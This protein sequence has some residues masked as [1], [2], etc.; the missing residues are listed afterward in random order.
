MEKVQ[1]SK[2]KR[3]RVYSFEPNALVRAYFSQLY[4]NYLLPA[5]LKV[6]NNRS[7]GANED[8]EIE[9]IVRFE[10]DM[11]L[12]L[13]ASGFRWSHAL[14]HK[15]KRDMVDVKASHPTSFSLFNYKHHNICRMREKLEEVSPLPPLP[16]PLFHVGSD[17]NPNP[18]SKNS[19]KKSMGVYK[20]RTRKRTRVTDEDEFGCRLRTLKRI[21]PGGDEMGTCELLSEV[22]SYVVC[23]EVQVSI[24]RTLV[25]SC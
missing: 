17:K 1:T 8:E 23:L 2:Q 5:L 19:Q 4:V 3:K 20:G 11:A 25:N 10:V 16:R 9:K 21:L 6:G 13:S 14:K 24:L 7:L 15:L 12:V 18:N 22:E